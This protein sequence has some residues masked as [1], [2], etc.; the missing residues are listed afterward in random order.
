M[1]FNKWVRTFNVGNVEG[2][3]SLYTNNSSLVSTFDSIFIND[4]NGIHN[5]FDKLLNKHA[6][7]RVLTV[8]VMKIDDHFLEF[9][10]YEFSYTNKIIN[11][12]FS[13][14]SNGES[15]IHHHSSI[16]N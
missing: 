15:I 14:L 10:I 16:C 2:V 7:V 8:N 4:L 6:K 5:Y 1:I 12:R 9:G 3:V 13:M 11:A